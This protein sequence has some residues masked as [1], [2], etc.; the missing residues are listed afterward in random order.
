M[1]AK[2]FKVGLIVPS[3][4]T[5]METEIPAMLRR[6]EC[7]V[8]DETFTFHSSRTRMQ[9]VT[10]D[11][12]KKMV[13]DSDRCAI[14]L[15]DARVDVMGYACLVAVMAQRAGFHTAAE[16]RL[17]GSPR[18]TVDRLRWSAALGVGA[19]SQSARGTQSNPRGAVHEAADETGHRLSSG[20]RHRGG[21]LDQPGGSQQSRSCPTG[22][23]KLPGLAEKLDRTGAEAVILSACVQMPSLPVIQQAEDRLGL[24]T[25][26][27]SVAT[28]YEILDRL[29]LDPVVPDAG[30]LLSGRLTSAAA[31]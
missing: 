18:T 27:A 15:S 12:L 21:R 26:S 30:R 19:R 17:P 23:A 16:E 5:T 28:T 3:S 2:N 29:G 22:P 9:N 20:L 8:P 6:R 7:E 4:N 14:E 25:I 13:R 11:E 1:S 10:E 24:P 31:R